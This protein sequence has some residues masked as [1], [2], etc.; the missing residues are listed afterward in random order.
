MSSK[1]GVFITYKAKAHYR[2]TR[3]RKRKVPNHTTKHVIKSQREQEDEKQKN[4]KTQNNNK[5]AISTFL[6]ITALNAD[7]LNSPNKRQR[8]GE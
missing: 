3:K 4:Y 6:S 2:C 1:S 8:V 5:M 7:E